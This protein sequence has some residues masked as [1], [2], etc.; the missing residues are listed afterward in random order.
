MSVNTKT[1]LAVPH[2]REH[3]IRGWEWGGGGSC[4]GGFG[5]KEQCIRSTILQT[6]A[7]GKYLVGHFLTY[8]E[9]NLW[10]SEPERTW[11]LSPLRLDESAIRR[12][13]HIS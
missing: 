9:G 11:Y 8:A 4:P 2:P 3:F 1:F 7:S 6:W 5:L 10:N 13:G 12:F